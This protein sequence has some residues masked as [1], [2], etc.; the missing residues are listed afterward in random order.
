V[1]KINFLATQ[2]AKQALLQVQSTARM[3]RAA[4]KTRLAS[5][6]PA[7]AAIIAL[8]RAIAVIQ[9]LRLLPVE[10]N[11]WQAQNLWHQ[12]WQEL[13]QQPAK[14]AARKADLAAEAA[15]DSWTARLRLLGTLMDLAVD[16]LYV[17]E[18][19]TT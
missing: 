16:E 6:E 15:A 5:R 10:L 19:A 17:E 9:T 8:E 14:S 7:E 1:Q 4:A 12:V 13:R 3:A 18:T 2:R 11:L